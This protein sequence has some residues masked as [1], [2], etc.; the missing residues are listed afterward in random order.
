MPRRN[1]HGTSDAAVHAADRYLAKESEY[2]SGIR[3]I[4]ASAALLAERL[5]LKGD[6]ESALLQHKKDSDEFETHCQEAE[7]F[8]NE[9]R[10]RL[11]T[12]SEGNVMK[13]REID[14]I[15][16]A[17]GDVRDEVQQKDFE[18]QQRSRESA[19]DSS[20]QDEIIEDIDTSLPDY[21]TSIMLKIEQIQ[22]QE[23]DIDVQDE[24]FAIEIRNRL[25]EKESKKRKKRGSAAAD[26]EE[27]LEIVRNHGAQEQESM[28]KCPITGR[29]FENPVKNSVCG[30]V[31]SA[32]GL[33]H[34]LKSKNHQ[35]PVAGCTN[36]KLT[37]DQVEDDPETV[38]KVRRYQR[39]LEQEK[40]QLSQFEEEELGEADEEGA[41]TGRMT[42]IE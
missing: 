38:M 33:K 25:G 24:D 13:M 34:L 37:K 19:Q 36:N 9:Q 23:E 29:L 32:Q 4:Q 10:R 5:A 31:Y 17:V 26:D 16:K 3:Q 22:E 35:C 28:F 1:V 14:R 20:G 41:V 18:E 42:V 21:E 12:L 8:L 7:S 15:V 40:A 27:E 30:H 6:I 11:K 39:R 2:R